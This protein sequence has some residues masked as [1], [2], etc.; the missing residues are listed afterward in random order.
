MVSVTIFVNYI[1]VADVVYFDLWAYAILELTKQ[2][3]VSIV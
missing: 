1:E 2:V 3:G